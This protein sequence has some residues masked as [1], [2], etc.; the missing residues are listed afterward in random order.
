VTAAVRA[1]NGAPRP[2]LARK[3]EPLTDSALEA[4]ARVTAMLQRATMKALPRRLPQRRRRKSSAK[5]Q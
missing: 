4:V 2:D 1:T 5:R 3:M